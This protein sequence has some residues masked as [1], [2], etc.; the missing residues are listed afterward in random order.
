MLLCAFHGRSGAKD[1]PPLTRDVTVFDRHL[2][3]AARVARRSVPE[4]SIPLHSTQRW[5]LTTVAGEFAILFLAQVRLRRFPVSRA[6]R[7]FVGATGMFAHY[8]AL[9]DEVMRA[10]ARERADVVPVNFL[11]NA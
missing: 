5:D 10:M 7:L 3:D 6:Q 8:V 2:A 4:T 11:R 1:A 9:R